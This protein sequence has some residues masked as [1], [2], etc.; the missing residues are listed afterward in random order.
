VFGWATRAY[1]RNAYCHRAC[2]VTAIRAHPQ[3]AK[4]ADERLTSRRKSLRATRAQ[5]ADLNL[6]LAAFASFTAA[7]AKRLLSLDGG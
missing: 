1:E 5:Q 6:A 2:S 3:S 4:K 7:A